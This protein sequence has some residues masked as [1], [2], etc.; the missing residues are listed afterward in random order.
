MRLPL[1]SYKLEVLLLT[2]SRQSRKRTISTLGSKTEFHASS[3]GCAS[4]YGPLHG[5]ANEA[6]IRM[7]ISIGSPKNVPAFL[8]QVKKREKVL[9]GFGHRYVS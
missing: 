5:G 9:S 2:H 4:L 6:V 7:L 1:P 3:A 8:E